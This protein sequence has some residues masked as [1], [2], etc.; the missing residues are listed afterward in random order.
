MET[1]QIPSYRNLTQR[2]VISQENL[3]S[4]IS[5]YSLFPQYKKSYELVPDGDICTSKVIRNHE[6]R[7]SMLQ[8]GFTLVCACT[9]TP[10]CYIMWY[11]IKIAKNPTALAFRALLSSSKQR[12]LIRVFLNPTVRKKFI[13]LASLQKALLA[14]VQQGDNRIRRYFP[15]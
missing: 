9:W 13:K 15:A 12:H 10:M 5:K 4:H 7:W 1:A 11:R 14:W 2:N 3:E 8:L 6:P